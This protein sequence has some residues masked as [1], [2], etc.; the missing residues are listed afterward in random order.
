MDLSDNVP[1]V[2][3]R[4]VHVNAIWQIVM[5]AD[6]CNPLRAR[7]QRHGGEGWAIFKDSVDEEECANG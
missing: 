4:R 2:L 5:S 7:M 1:C 6:S 3:V